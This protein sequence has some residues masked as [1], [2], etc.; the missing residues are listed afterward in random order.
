MKAGAADASETV[1]ER[2]RAGRVEVEVGR[3]R[4]FVRPHRRRWGDRESVRSEGLEGLQS[5]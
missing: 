1:A 3:G 5:G 4:R 2:L